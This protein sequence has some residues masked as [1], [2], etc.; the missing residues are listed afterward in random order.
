MCIYSFLSTIDLCLSVN[1]QPR[2][3][4][5]TVSYLTGQIASDIVM[6]M[7]IHNQSFSVL[8][9]ICRCICNGIIMLCALFIHVSSNAEK[10]QA[11]VGVIQCYLLSRCIHS[12][13]F[14]GYN[15]FQTKIK[16]LCEV[17]IIWGVQ[18]HKSHKV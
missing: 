17:S 3:H 5:D 4:K 8:H 9:R 12:S 6:P 14:T 10:T 7:N 16:S 2:E 11:S 13:E 1:T 18:F 15:V